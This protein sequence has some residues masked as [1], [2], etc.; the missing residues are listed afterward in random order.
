MLTTSKCDLIVIGASLG[1]MEALKELFADLPQNLAASVLVVWHVPPQTYNLLPDILNRVT[2]LD[3][4][5][6]QDCV[7]IQSGRAYI[8]PSDFHL[9]I[10]VD[11]DDEARIRL[12]RSPKENNFRPSI[13]VLFRSAAVAMGGRVIGVV[14]TGLLD[15]GASGLY[16]I[17]N[18]GGLAVV[19]DPI[20]AQ[21]PN[22]PINA[23]RAVKIDYVVPIA[24]MGKLLTKLVNQPVQE[25]E[26]SVDRQSAFP[27]LQAEVRI[28]LQDNNLPQDSIQ[29]G[30]VSPYTC[31]ECH[32]SLIQIMEGNITRFRC[33]TGHAFTLDALLSAI[34]QSCEATLWNA[35]RVLQ[36]AEMLIE[37]LSKH[38]S[39]LGDDEAALAYLQRKVQ[40]VQQANLVRQALIKDGQEMQ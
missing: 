14:L 17:K 20:D 7:A 39:E 12:T 23:I 5:A 11:E 34:T 21:A 16:A 15:D 27:N 13:D 25:G 36:E 19:Q 37:H 2:Q 28:A 3:V 38:L 22:M 30:T 35:V 33:H 24:Q 32:G 18:C 6:A 4:V 8:A 10:E 29:L 9:V 40:V 31:P 26:M 1:G